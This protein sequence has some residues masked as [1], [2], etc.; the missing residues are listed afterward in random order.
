MMSCRQCQGLSPAGA[1][2][3]GAGNQ[4]EAP[5]SNGGTNAGGSVFI[6]PSLDAESLK[7]TWKNA[8]A[9]RRWAPSD[10]EV[11][12]AYYSTVLDRDNE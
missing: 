10:D 5:V 11:V 4:N 9:A 12:R 2:T 3:G 7:L 1:G 8:F 6:P